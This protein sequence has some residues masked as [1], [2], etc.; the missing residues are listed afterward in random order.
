[1]KLVMAACAPRKSMEPI[2]VD[3]VTILGKV[4]GAYLHFQ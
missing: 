1:M 4:V 3:Q 2:I